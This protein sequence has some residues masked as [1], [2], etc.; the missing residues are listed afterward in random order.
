MEV[1]SVG[2]QIELFKS[3]GGGFPMNRF[4]LTILE[5]TMWSTLSNHSPY[6]YIHIVHV[7]VFLCVCERLD[8]STYPWLGDKV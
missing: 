2:L 1:N 6:L 7:C 3:L 5:H 8:C 4:N